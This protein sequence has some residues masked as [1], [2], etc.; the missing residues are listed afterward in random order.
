MKVLF[1]SI[2]ISAFSPIEDLPI[3]AVNLKNTIKTQTSTKSGK[4]CGKTTK[5]ADRPKYGLQN[6]TGT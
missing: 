1:R 4:H 3:P 2:N 6:L 5:N